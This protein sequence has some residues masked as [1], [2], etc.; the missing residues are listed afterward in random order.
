[1]EYLE[2]DTLAVRISQRPLPRE[3]LPAIAVQIRALAHAHRQ[4]ILHR[5]LKP[6]NVMITR[7]RVRLL[8]FGLAKLSQPAKVSDPSVPDQPTISLELTNRSHR[9]HVALHGPGT[10]RRETRR[11]TH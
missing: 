10:I 3:S 5:D 9:G 1:M 6:G 8:D 4:G 11:C 7:D 2:G